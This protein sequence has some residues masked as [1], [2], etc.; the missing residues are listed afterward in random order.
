M[1]S[2]IILKLEG[3]SMLEEMKKKGKRSLVDVYAL[4][5][6]W[7]DKRVPWYA[8]LV[9]AAVVGYAFSP[10][11]LI[12]DFIPVLGQL[13]DLLLIP[14]GV[15]LAIRLIPEDVLEEHREQAKKLAA[16]RGRHSWVAGGIIIVVWLLI[17]RLVFGYLKLQGSS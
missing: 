15:A 6:V 8:R 13:D 11:D 1:M 3:R 9:A 10:I 14:L 12:P 16:S 17:I 5:L 7:R 2:N 4:L